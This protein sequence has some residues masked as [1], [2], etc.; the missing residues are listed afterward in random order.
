MSS[1]GYRLTP[2]GCSDV[3]ACDEILA[4]PAPAEGKGWAF[5]VGRTDG[6]AESFLSDCDAA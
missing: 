3:D 1:M 2:I 4:T 5:E 6:C